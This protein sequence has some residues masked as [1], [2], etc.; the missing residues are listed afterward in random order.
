MVSHLMLLVSLSKMYVS[1]EVKLTDV[2]VDVN[3][4]TQREIQAVDSDYLVIETK[5]TSL[6]HADEIGLGVFA[7]YNIPANEIICE[8]RGIVIDSKV[9]VD[10]TMLS[11]LF[12]LD[13]EFGDEKTRRLLGAWPETDVGL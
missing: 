6:P 2:E 11:K 7:K 10:R 12:T 8:Y 3:S 9:D 5:P 13:F 4:I 1:Q